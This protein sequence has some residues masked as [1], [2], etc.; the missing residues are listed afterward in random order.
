MEGYRRLLE[1]S[2]LHLG[3]AIAGGLLFEAIYLFGETGVGRTAYSVSLYGFTLG[4]IS[5]AFLLLLW[6]Y[7][8]NGGIFLLLS[9]IAVLSWF[10]GILFYTSY[11]FI[12]GE[13]LVYPSVAQFAFHG[14]HLLMVPLLFY[15]MNRKGVRFWKPASLPVVG[16]FAFPFVAYAIIGTGM[17]VVAYNVFYL[18]V[19]VLAT[20]LAAHLVVKR[21]LPLFGASLLVFFT[22]DIYFITTTLVKRDPAILFLHPIWF[23]ASALVSYS[24]VRYASEGVFPMNSAKSARDN[25]G[26]GNE[27]R[28]DAESG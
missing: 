16:A 18:T 26:H 2:S 24:L 14:F 11:V 22:A 9:G 5:T 13:V 10:L 7:R 15:V 20:V 28:G 1:A 4:V 12:L 17:I 27:C 23:T 8:A 19:T 21:K 6:G 25:K 3:L